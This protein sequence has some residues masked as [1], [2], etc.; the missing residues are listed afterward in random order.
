MIETI[1]G[2]RNKFKEWKEAYDRKCLKINF[3][4]TQMIVKGSIVKDGLS[5]NEIFHC[6]VLSLMAKANSVWSV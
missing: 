5:K 3:G 4:K 2:L 6:G 1:V